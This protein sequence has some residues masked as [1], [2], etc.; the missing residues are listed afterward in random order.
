MC[1]TKW[2]WCHRRRGRGRG[3]AA[4]QN[5]G[6]TIVHFHPFLRF[7]KFTIKLANAKVQ[8]RATAVRAPVANQCKEHHVEKQI[9][10]VAMLSSMSLTIRSIIRLDVVA[11]QIFEIPRHSPKIRTYNSSMSSMV[12]DLCANRKRICNS[13]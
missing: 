12:N 11:S 3:S 1:R 4:S 6:L 7:F 13:Y 9:Q 10:W 8:L 2:T 5:F